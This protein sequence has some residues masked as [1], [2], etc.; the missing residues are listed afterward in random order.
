MGLDGV[1]PGALRRALHRA[2]RAEGVPVSQYQLVPL[3]AGWSYATAFAVRR[4][5]ARWA[6]EDSNL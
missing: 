1:Q 6:I 5:A 3:P 4:A 2:L